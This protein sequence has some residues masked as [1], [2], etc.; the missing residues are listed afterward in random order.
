MNKIIAVD[1][2][3]TLAVTNYPN[4]VEPIQPIINYIIEQKNQGCTIILNTCRHDEDLDDAVKW[5]EEQGVYFDLI[6]ENHPELIKQFGDC[7]KIA[8]DEYIDDKN[9]L[10]E[11]I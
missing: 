3:G 10:I 7:R 1:F 6:N 2:D 11:H 9:I 4:I 5:C 8:A